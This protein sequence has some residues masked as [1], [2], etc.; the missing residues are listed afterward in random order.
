MRHLRRSISE[1]KYLQ[2]FVALRISGG[3]LAVLCIANDRVLF[4]LSA[5]PAGPYLS[6]WQQMTPA[7]L[8]YVNQT[9]KLAGAFAVELSLYPY[10]SADNYVHVSAHSSCEVN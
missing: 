8:S 6:V 9:V 3:I 5:W 1:V 10:L 7:L 2:E 4:V